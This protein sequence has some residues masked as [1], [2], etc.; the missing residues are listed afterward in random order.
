VTNCHIETDTIIHFDTRISI[1]YCDLHNKWE[2]QTAVN[3][4][5]VV[6]LLETYVEKFAIPI[7]FASRSNML[8]LERVCIH[9]CVI[10]MICVLVAVRAT[11]DPFRNWEKPGIE[12][13]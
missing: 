7:Y 4:F 3:V 8:L 6:N 12:Y 10:R 2:S 5:E 11:S 9:G 13:T 1:T